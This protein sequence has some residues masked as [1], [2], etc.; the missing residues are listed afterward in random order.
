MTYGNLTEFGGFE[1]VQWQPGDA[2]GDPARVIHRLSTEFDGEHEWNGLLAGFLA[3]SGVERIQGLV[4]GYW[5][6]DSLMDEDPEALFAGALREAALGLPNLRVLYVNDISSEESEVSWITNTNLSPLVMAF[7]RLTHLGIRG[8]N[9]LELP[10]LDLPHLDTLIIESGGLSAELV[11]QVLT[12][13]LPRLRHLELYLGTDNYGATVQPDDLTPILDGARFPGLKY[14]G[15]KNSDLQDEIAQLLAPAPVTRGLEVLD[16]SMGIL[17]DEGGRAL[18][19]H[20]ADGTL[21]H[22]KKLDLEFHWMSEALCE[23][24]RAEAGR[25]GVEINVSDAQAD[26]DDWRYVA[27]GE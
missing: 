7:P 5:G 8:G 17:T 12:A 6:Q 25:Q 24:L 1:I 15:L 18:L 21:G 10:D 23:Q 9:S 20:L 13:R 19:E 27:L 11:R 22:L 2:L 4:V 26:D 16:L 3:Q 14:L